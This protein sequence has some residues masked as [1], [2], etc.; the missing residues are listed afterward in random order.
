MQF[1]LSDQ[2]RLV[3]LVMLCGILWSL[4][5]IAPLYRYQNSRVRHAL[6]NVALTLILV[7]TNLVL[8]F[9]SAYLAGFTVRSGFGLF[10]L[11]GIAAWIQAILGVAALDLFAY[12]AHVMLHKSWLGWQFHRVHHSENAVDVTTAFRQ[13]PGE[14]V[15]RMLWQLSAVVVFGI[16]LW[17]VVIYLILSALNAQMEHAN[18][19]LNVSADRLLRL[20]I[21]TP[22]MHKVHH[23][24][25]QRE[26]DSNYSNIFSFW[27]RLFGTYTAEIDFQRLRYGLDGFDARERQ[28]LRGLLKM[29]FV[30]YTRVSDG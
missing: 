12:F 25:D 8:S 10:P 1:W 22:H 5:S 21:V 2:S 18:I 19:R 15:W 28:T 26:T 4:E 24:R 17:V 9:G 23:S 3:A 20:M 6:P 29:P 7:L 27:D 11:F 14:T 30:N 16:P 13:H